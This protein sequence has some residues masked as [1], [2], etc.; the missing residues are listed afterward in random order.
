MSAQ[1]ISELNAAQVNLSTVEQQ[2]VQEQAQRPDTKTL[3]YIEVGD[4]ALHQNNGIVRFTLPGVTDTL[5]SE[6]I[7]VEY[8]ASNDYIWS[9]YLTKK[10]GYFSIVSKPE[11]KAGFFQFDNRFFKIE[12]LTSEVSLLKELEMTALPGAAGCSTIGESAL[13]LETDWCELE[14]NDCQAVID[15]LVLIPPDVQLW[16]NNQPNPLAGFL[17]VLQGITSV[18]LAFQNSGIPNKRIRWTSERFNFAYSFNLDAGTDLAQLSNTAT[19]IR[20]ERQADVVIMLTNMDYPDVAGFANNP[21]ACGNNPDNCAFAIVEVDFLVDPRWTF[22]H[23]FA[24]LLRARHNRPDNCSNLLVCGDNDDDVCGHGFVFDDAQGIERRTIMSRMF[25]I[26]TNFGSQR[27]LHFSNPEVLFN[28]GATGD[29]DNNNA[30]IIRNTACDVANYRKAQEWT[31]NLYGTYQL[32][33][34][35]SIDLFAVSTPPQ[36]GWWMFQGQAPYQYEWRWSNSPIFAP[37]TLISSGTNTSINIS[38]PYA[39]PYFWIQVKITSAD[40]FTR[41]LSQRI[42]VVSPEECLFS[43]QDIGDPGFQSNESQIPAKFTIFPNPANQELNITSKEAWPKHTLI[44]IYDQLGHVVKVVSPEDDLSL[45]I[46]LGFLQAG[47]YHLG[48]KA[49]GLNEVHKIAI[50]HP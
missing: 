15:V 5:H 47:F 20:N 10:P 3:K 11:G 32:C 14:N 9:G 49:D 44:T 34:G 22:A 46:D 42:R 27:L 1:I 28:G 8:N 45:I 21:D 24:H 13:V 30:R 37:G 6:A 36:E 48:I 26:E 18:D 2:F 7:Q 50:F 35:E 41:T 17:S 12:P 38:T 31:V 19:L 29:A 43:L 33:E 4:I 16:I 23:E 40:G 25:D 39:E